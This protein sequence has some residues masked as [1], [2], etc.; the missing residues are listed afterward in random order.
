MNADKTNQPCGKSRK[1]LVVKEFSLLH[2]HTCTH[3]E[4]TRL[5]LRGPT[6]IQLHITIPFIPHREHNP[7]PLQ[8]S[9]VV[10][11][12]SSRWALSQ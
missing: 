6:F 11:E 1:N 12:N 9:I 5:T 2:S 7:C 3:E 10:N 8:K 4:V